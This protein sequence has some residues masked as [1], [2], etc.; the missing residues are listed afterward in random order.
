MALGVPTVAYDHEVVSDLRASGGGLL[1]KSPGEFVDAVVA[2]AQ[3][4][5]GRRRLGE[6]AR[7]YAGA[8]RWETLARRYDREVLHQYLSDTSDT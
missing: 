1:V 6:N 4:E 5:A 2:L 7:Q 3:D 8:W